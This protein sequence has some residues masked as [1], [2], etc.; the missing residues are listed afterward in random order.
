MD[1]PS[2]QAS[3]RRVRPLDDEE[4]ETWAGP[5]RPSVV[6]VVVDFH[7]EQSGS[8][9]AAALAPPPPVASRA[10]AP[11]VVPPLPL[12]VHSGRGGGNPG[13][14][15]LSLRTKHILHYATISVAFIVF[16]LVIWGGYDA[17]RPAQGEAGSPLR[18][19]SAGSGWVDPDCASYVD[20]I[21]TTATGTA[22]G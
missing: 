10:L 3:P 14:G 15:L 11:L 4:E 5:S 9:T 13:G 19:Y 8:G 21:N 20:C 2:G 18:A 12:P 17:L 16:G 7:E 22:R 6:E 1:E